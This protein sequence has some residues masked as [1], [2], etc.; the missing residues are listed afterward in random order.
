M[1]HQIG[2]LPCNE[3]KV[4]NRTNNADQCVASET[5]SRSLWLVAPMGSVWWCKK[6]NE[7]SND[8]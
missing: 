2:G 4:K 7:V 5:V 8:R 1:E 6:R 3:Y